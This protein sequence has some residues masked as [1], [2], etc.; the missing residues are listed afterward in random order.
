MTPIRVQVL[1]ALGHKINFAMMV[2][3]EK[4][5]GI[6]SISLHLD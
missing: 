3:D 6:I 2:L 5:G 4:Q 1:H